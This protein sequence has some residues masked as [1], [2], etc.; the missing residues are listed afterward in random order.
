MKVALWASEMPAGMRGL[1]VPALRQTSN[2]KEKRVDTNFFQIQELL[3]ER[4]Q[5]KAHLSLIPYDG[6]VEIKEHEGKKYIYTRKRV[7]GKNTSTY[8]D[9]YSD[10]T[11]AAVSSLL[12]QAKQYKKKIRQI[13]K[14]LAALGYCERELSPRVLLNI[15]FAR[16]NMKANIYDQ[17]ILEGIATTFSDT[18]TIIDNG[19]V[20]GMRASDVQKIIN[21][22][23]AWEFIMDEDV[24]ASD[25]GYSVLCRIAG[26]V[27]EGF[28]A[29]GGKMRGVPVAIGGT[30]YV[31]PLPMEFVVKETIEAIL[32]KD[33]PPVDIA[34]ELC[35]Y[36]MKAQL[37]NDGNKRTA[38]IFANYYLIS[39][40]A[41]L[42]VIP[43]SKVSEFKGLLIAYYEDKDTGEIAQFMKR[44]CYKAF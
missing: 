39:K 31:P 3:Q 34:I 35:L 1:G 21:L 5:I 28:Y 8:I 44:D 18:E 12:Q 43:E 17:A 41:G 38:V 10:A 37:F 36:C 9:V 22:K 23:H 6:S 14:E 42:L 11:F 29:Y 33:A 32:A 13:D 24:V 16:A 19:K 30:S 40:G 4:A 20:S 2:G 15:D 7:L 27:N 25:M 26:L